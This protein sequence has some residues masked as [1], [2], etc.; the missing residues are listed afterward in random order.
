MDRSYE[1]NMA[2]AGANVYRHHNHHELCESSRGLA[3]G[4]VRCTCKDLFKRDEKVKE[5]D[6][7][8]VK[9]TR[10]E[11]FIQLCGSDELKAF[12]ADLNTWKLE[13]PVKEE[14]ESDNHIGGCDS[15]SE[16]TKD[17]T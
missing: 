8:T 13:D 11:T 3:I 6:L 1:G 9:Y 7:L 17:E 2:R 10:L 15:L 16:D 14:Q 5:Y 12:L 4:S